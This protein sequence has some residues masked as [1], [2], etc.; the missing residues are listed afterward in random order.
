MA[1]LAVV[2]V[3][4]EQAYCGSNLYL[5]T[6]ARGLCDTT[7]VPAGLGGHCP[8]CLIS[9]LPPVSGWLLKFPTVSVCRQFICS[10][11][12]QIAPLLPESLALRLFPTYTI[13]VCRIERTG[14][15]DTTREGPLEIQ[16]EL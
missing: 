13:Y 8:C 5:V 12:I 4:N 1:F 15:S 11:W 9:V 10:W 7:F 14:S 6:L 16:E 2:P 3:P